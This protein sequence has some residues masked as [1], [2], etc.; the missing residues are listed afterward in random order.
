M[1]EVKNIVIEFFN[2]ELKARGFQFSEN[3]EKAQD[4]IN[5]YYNFCIE[6]LHEMLG[7]SFLREDELDEDEIEEEVY[8]T[9]RYIFKISNYKNDI[10]GEIYIVY[11]SGFLSS[12]MF[13]EVLNMTDFY[14][15]GKIESQGWK[16]LKN[17]AIDF[18]NP[19]NWEDGHGPE[20]LSIKKLGQFI[21][22]ERY[23]EPEDDDDEM[24]KYLADE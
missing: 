10:Y 24:K 2:T 19:E 1:N 17:G 16:V 4:E 18:D 20:D 3:R 6:D 21:S 11:C 5:H 8:E 14:I 7:I 12:P 15:L 13:S 9:P 22:T 23:L